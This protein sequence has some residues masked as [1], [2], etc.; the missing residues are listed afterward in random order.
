[1]KINKKGNIKVESMI[2]PKK[3]NMEAKNEK[4]QTWDE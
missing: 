2:L 3:Q 1:M 4:P